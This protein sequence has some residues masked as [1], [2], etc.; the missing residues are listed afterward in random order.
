MYIGAYILCDSFV[1]NFIAGDNGTA[2]LWVTVSPF[3][4][5]ILGHP[6]HTLL[7]CAIL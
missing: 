1:P 6:P 3:F 7:T 2:N 4:G 5:V